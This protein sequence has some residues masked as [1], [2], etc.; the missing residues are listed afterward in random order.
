VRTAVHRVRPTLKDRN[1][2]SI[3]Q[4]GQVNNLNDGMAWGLFPSFFA[5]SGMSLE[6][7]AVLAATY[8]AVWGVVQLATGALS[9]RIGR[10]WLIASGMWTQ[11]IGIAATV[12]SENFI[13]FAA[14]G[15]LGGHQRR[16]A[17][18]GRCDVDRRRSD[19]CLRVGDCAAHA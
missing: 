5:A 4:A 15:I 8:A 12:V 7:I 10:K 11:A 14:G 1:L 19:V 9:D 17:R 2:S 16:P 6:R 18:S 13:G 3:S